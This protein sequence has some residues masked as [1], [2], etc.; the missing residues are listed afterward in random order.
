MS[1]G[2]TEDRFLRLMYQI[3]EMEIYLNT[4][5]YQDW[6][7]F[8][9]PQ[10]QEQFEDLT[11]GLSSPEYYMKSEERTFS[12]ETPRDPRR[13]RSTSRL[14]EDVAEVPVEQGRRMGSRSRSQPQTSQEDE[15]REHPHHSKS[16]AT[17]SL[18]F[19]HH[20]H[21]QRKW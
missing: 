6:S 15:K 13:E 20:G 12:A 8:P 5:G 10:K 19:L 14:S 2:W 16:K 21:N 18:V 3:P 9:I 4:Y 7:Q 11:P 1:G 17:L